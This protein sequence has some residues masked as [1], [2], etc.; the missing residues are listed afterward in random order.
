M[1]SEEENS[2]T[3]SCRKALKQPCRFHYPQRLKSPLLQHGQARQ[4]RAQRQG[5]DPRA[6]PP[7]KH[8]GVQ[9]VFFS[10]LTGVI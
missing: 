6:D 1:H 9:E 8:F 7:A 4:G 5:A 10:Q 3:G 2:L